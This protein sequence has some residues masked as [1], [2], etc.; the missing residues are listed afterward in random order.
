M[1]PKDDIKKLLANDRKDIRK[2]IK[3]RKLDVDDPILYSRIYQFNKHR[4]IGIIEI[5]IWIR[6]SEYHRENGPYIPYYRINPLVDYCI[7]EFKKNTVDESKSKVLTRDYYLTILS[8]RKFILH[9]LKSG[10]YIIRS[11]CYELGKL[12]KE[13]YDGSLLF[14][15]T[16]YLSRI[17]EDLKVNI[18]QWENLISSINLSNY[19]TKETL[20][21]FQSILTKS[22][23]IENF[24]QIISQIND[25]NQNS[26][27][28]ILVLKQKIGVFQSRFIKDLHKNKP[29]SEIIS[30]IDD[31][32]ENYKFVIEEFHLKS[33]KIQELIKDNLE[34]IEIINQ[35]TDSIINLITELNLLSD[36]SQISDS[37]I[38]IR[39]LSQR[40]LQINKN[41]NK[42]TSNFIFSSLEVI[43]SRSI[44]LNN[45]FSYLR[46]LID[47][48]E[49]VGNPFYIWVYGIHNILENLRN[50]ST[51]PI[52]SLNAIKPIMRSSNKI[53]D[54]YLEEYVLDF[55]EENHQR[56][57]NKLIKNR[58]KEAYLRKTKVKEEIIR[59][60]KK[61]EEEKEII[62]KIIKYILKS[63]IKT[64]N[65]P[66]IIIDWFNVNHKNNSLVN[67]DEFFNNLV[68][69]IFIHLKDRIEKFE[70]NK[71]KLEDFEDKFYILNDNKKIRI[72]SRI[73]E[74]KR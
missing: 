28:L 8:K 38:N 10:G 63:E 23:E 19:Y 48:T 52:L 71:S 47:Q 3:N 69:D 41:I 57:L 13:I 26:N 51:L 18:A 27:D 54:R 67:L 36:K 5:F 30:E 32:I 45:L 50:N 62:E 66:K 53:S 25:L 4:E 37:N 31:F 6:L 56:D 44:L 9:D 14:Y 29:Y 39:D 64:L 70:N 72:K 34:T 12:F 2:V 61:K 46:Q 22:Q 59:E 60:K 35:R 16:N 24:N 17:L 68:L 15:D 21:I 1:K 73:L 55:S 43:S 11:N 74:L 42:F 49:L 65:I 7:I 33:E 20:K 58:N 40:V